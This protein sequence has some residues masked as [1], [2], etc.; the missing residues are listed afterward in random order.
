MDNQDLYGR[1]VSPLPTRDAIQRGIPARSKWLSL[2]VTD[3]AVASALKDVRL[4]SLAAGED[5]SACADRMA[6]AIALTR[7][8]R[9]PASSVLAFHNTIAVPATSAA[10]FAP[11]PRVVAVPA[12]FVS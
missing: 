5:G 12:A 10:T 7:G 4:I 8:R 3:S 1:R 11:A 6:A 2:L 9:L